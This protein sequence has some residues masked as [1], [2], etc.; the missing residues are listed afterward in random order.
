MEGICMCVCVCVCLLAVHGGGQ[1]VTRSLQLK[2][3]KGDL[4]VKFFLQDELYTLA[5][6]VLMSQEKCV[7]LDS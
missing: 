3:Q 7:E 4:I 2:I 6:F 1:I 5:T